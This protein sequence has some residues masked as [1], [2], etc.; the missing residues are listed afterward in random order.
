MNRR[1]FSVHL[2]AAAAATTLADAARAQGGTPV[3]GTHYVQLNQPLQ[4]PPGKIDRE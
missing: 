3:E 1:E 4:V 2:L